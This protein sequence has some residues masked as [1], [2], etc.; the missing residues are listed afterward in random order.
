MNTNEKESESFPW[1]H[2]RRYNAWSEQIKKKFGGRVQKLSVDAGFDCPN[3]DGSIAYGGCTYCNNKAFSPSYCRQHPD[4]SRQIKEG[5][6][7]HQ[8]RYRR[9]KSF[10]VYFQ[11]YT[12]THAGID[13]LMGLYEQA[14][15]QPQISGLV[16]GTRPDCMPDELLSYL[17]Q[18]A[19]NHYIMIEYGVE[20][21]YDT[22]LQR[23][24]R[25]HTFRQS[26]DAIERTHAAGL[27][28]G[29]HLI[30]GLPGETRQQILDAVNTISALPLS[31]VKFHQLQIF[32]NTPLAVQYDQNASAFKLFTLQDYIEF[33]IDFTERLHP[34]I[35]IER[36][37]GEASPKQLH[38]QNWG[39]KRYD[40]VLQMIEERMEA[41]NTWQGKYFKV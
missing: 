23:I 24:N 33:I 29:A 35:A 18:L 11:S 1:G 14:L 2:K 6:A 37:A 10:W 34:A 27:H 15:A 38:I 39:S 26:A 36:F 41:R 31:S 12:N 40:T 5:L 16:I 28:C 17:Q 21:I 3:R 32:R 8:K 30:F 7:F 19:K 9:V 20:S 25:G 13:K 22:T 4:I